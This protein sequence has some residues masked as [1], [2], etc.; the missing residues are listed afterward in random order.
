M[1]RANKY[2]NIFDVLSLYEFLHNKLLQT[3]IVT[4]YIGHSS[5]GL[6]GLVWSDCINMNLVCDIESFTY[7]FM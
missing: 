7:Y 3:R 5:L 1:W 6:W 4:Y 2:C